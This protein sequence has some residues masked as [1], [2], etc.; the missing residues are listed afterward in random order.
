M[1]TFEPSSSI[2]PASVPNPEAAELSSTA[3]GLAASAVTSW[4]GRLAELAQL[5]SALPEAGHEED[6]MAQS[7][8]FHLDAIESILRDPRPALSREVAKC[9]PS[10]V[11]RGRSAVEDMSRVSSP[12]PL[13]APDQHCDESLVDNGFAKTKMLA[14]LSTLLTEVND[15]HIQLGNRRREAS[16]ICDL[17]EERC[18]GLQRT[19]AELELEVVE[20]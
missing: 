11:A 17:Y 9:R 8:H 7:V 6:E 16:E 13:R 10:G 14:Q 20:L 4:S 5:A 1:A 2:A 12:P 15:L 3:D 18:R 19:V